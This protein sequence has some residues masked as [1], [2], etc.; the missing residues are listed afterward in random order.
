[1]MMVVVVVV[2]IRVTPDLSTMYL[3]LTLKPVYW[4]RHLQFRFAMHSRRCISVISKP[5]NL[6]GKAILQQQHID[7]HRLSMNVM[8]H[9]NAKHLR[10]ATHRMLPVH[11]STHIHGV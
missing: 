4:H 8:L 2:D 11:C 5:H 3:Q 10:S 1:M 7:I 6:Q 9:Y